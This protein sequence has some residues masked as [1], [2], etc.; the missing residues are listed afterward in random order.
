MVE[1]L[2]QTAVKS[3]LFALDH[4]KLLWYQYSRV[5]RDSI[6]IRTSP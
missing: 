6:I 3:D 1:D 4:M 2:P 5:L